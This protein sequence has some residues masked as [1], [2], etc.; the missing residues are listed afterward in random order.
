MLKKLGRGQKND[1]NNLFDCTFELANLYID[2]LT[3]T[4]AACEP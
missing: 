4:R 2:S 1:H 3:P